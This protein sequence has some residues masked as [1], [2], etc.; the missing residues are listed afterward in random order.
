MHGGRHRW[1]TR[2]TVAGEIPDNGAGCR[3]RDPVHISTH[4]GSV[5]DTLQ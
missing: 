1:I 3:I 4:N 5:R 2:H